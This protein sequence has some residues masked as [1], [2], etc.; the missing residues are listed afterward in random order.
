MEPPILFAELDMQGAVL[1]PTPGYA[2]IAGTAAFLAGAVPERIDE[3]RARFARYARAAGHRWPALLNVA[4][5]LPPR[6]IDWSRNNDVPPG[7]A[8]AQPLEWL[9][10]FVAGRCTG[11]GF[12]R[13]WLRARGLAQANGETALDQVFWLLEDY[14]IDPTFREREDLSEDELSQAVRAVEAWRA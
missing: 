5:S 11:A 9:S 7:T 14:S 1:F 4:S 8:T 12:A 3:I 13:G 10:A 6:H 2:L